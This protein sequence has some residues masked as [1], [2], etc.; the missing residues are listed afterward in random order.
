MVIIISIL[1]ISYQH[2]LVRNTLSYFDERKHSR[3]NGGTTARITVILVLINGLLVDL[4]AYRS[5]Q[6]RYSYA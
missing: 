1:A 5:H 4:V 6:G 3:G 2:K